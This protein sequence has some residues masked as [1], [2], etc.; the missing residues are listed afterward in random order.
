MK[1]FGAY[2][3]VG[4]V[5]PA[6]IATV[7]AVVGIAW[8]RGPLDPATVKLPA[9]TPALNLGKLNYDVKC[10]SCHGLNAA[11]TD[12]GPTFLHRVYHPG[13]HDD[14]AFYLAP[15]RGVR[16][17]HWPYGDMPPVPGVTDAQIEKIVL[18]VRAL[19]REN[20]IY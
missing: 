19:Q 12:K 10:A 13:H 3:R 11:G 15:K 5:L 8:A 2:R 17:H 18:Y 9:M 14:G 20:G 7:V 4:I 6:V 1:T 16:A